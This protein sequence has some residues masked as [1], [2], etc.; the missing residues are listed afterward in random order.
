MEVQPP[1]PSATNGPIMPGAP[2]FAAGMPPNLAGGDG[3][4]PLFPPPGDIHLPQPPPDHILVNGHHPAAHLPGQRRHILG[5]PPHTPGGSLPLEVR[6][7]SLHH[8]HHEGPPPPWMEEAGPPGDGVAPPPPPA[9]S[10][11]ETFIPPTASQVSPPGGMTNVVS[12]SVG[13]P[14][15]QGGPHPPPPPGANNKK[16]SSRRNAWGNLSYADLITQAI[17]SAPEKRLTLSQ[18]Y[19]WMVQNIPYFKDKGDSNSSAGWKVRP[20]AIKESIRRPLNQRLGGN[21]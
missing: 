14:D 18:V 4:T 7:L 5:S 10:T 3:Q 13:E 6:R 11:G 12:S 9:I 1:P 15:G 16:S 21:H 19:E 8:P 2:H 17:Q 20:L